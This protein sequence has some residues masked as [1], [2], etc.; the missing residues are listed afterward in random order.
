MKIHFLILALGLTFY[1]CTS[2][3][4]QE[5][6]STERVVNQ[7]H[8]EI[9]I[10]ILALDSNLI[11]SKT[12]D[13]ML[14]TATTQLEKCEL[15]LDEYKMATNKPV[16][17]LKAANACR[18]LKQPEKALV[19]LNRFIRSYKDNELRDEVLFTKAFILDEDLGD[20]Q[21]AKDTYTQLIR[22]FPNSVFHDNAQIL[23]E[24]L[25]LS[26]AEL[27]EKFRKQNKE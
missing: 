25:Y 20:K 15:Y 1:S 4:N 7:T 11:N 3:S 2:N 12:L 22:E 23:L 13:G 10:D 6:E 9:L 27:I 17:L 19:F 24:Q 26:D 18:A 8:D 14:A 21:K 5:T 16:V